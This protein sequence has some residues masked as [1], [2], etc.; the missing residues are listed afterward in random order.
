[1]EL[2]ICLM[3]DESAIFIIN[4]YYGEKLEDGAIFEIYDIN[5][6]LIGTYE[7]ENGIINIKLEYG[8]YYGIQ[9]S[10]VSGYNLV[11]KFDI[12]IKEEKEYNDFFVFFCHILLLCQRILR[13]RQV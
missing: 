2:P 9:T 12:S 4:K 10:G 1:M 5:N 7:T 11:D 6:N 8:E 13:R 3:T